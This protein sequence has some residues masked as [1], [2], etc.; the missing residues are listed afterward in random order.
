[1]TT[2]TKGAIVVC[3]QDLLVN[4]RLPDGSYERVWRY[5]AELNP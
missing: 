4:R 5:R 2:G 3:A 1:V